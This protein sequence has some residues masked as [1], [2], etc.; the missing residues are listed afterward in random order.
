MLVPNTPRQAKQSQ[1]PEPPTPQRRRNRLF[2][3]V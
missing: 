1:S 2:W 3:S